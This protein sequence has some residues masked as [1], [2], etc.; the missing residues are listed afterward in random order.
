MTDKTPIL[1][2]G[3]SGFEFSHQ[4]KYQANF[5][6]PTVPFPPTWDGDYTVEAHVKRPRMVKHWRGRK[7]VVR[8]P[9]QFHTVVFEKGR[10]RRYVNGTPIQSRS[11]LEDKKFRGH[12]DEFRLFDIARSAGHFIHHTVTR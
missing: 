2:L 5:C 9:W 10:T 4:A 6:E 12:I 7:F 8:D 11:P 1:L 3:A